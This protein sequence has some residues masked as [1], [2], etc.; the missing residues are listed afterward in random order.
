MKVI[1]VDD[2]II[3]RAGMRMIIPWE[4]LGFY[5]AGEAASAEEGMRLA[6]EVHPELMLVDITMPGMDGIEMIKILKNEL[7]LCRF[8]ILTCH[9]EIQYLTS[10]IRV[11]VADYIIK[12]ALNPEEITQTLRD[13]KEKFISEKNTDGADEQIKKVEALFMKA[14][15]T[16]QITCR[17]FIKQIGVHDEGESTFFVF[18]SEVKK[19][20]NISAAE[21]I[22][23]QVIKEYAKFSFHYC[24]ENKIVFLIVLK[25]G[26]SPMQ[27][28]SHRCMETLTSNFFMEVSAGTS[29]P[30]NEHSLLKQ[31]VKQAMA[32]ADMRWI[33]GWNCAHFYSL[34]REKDNMRFFSE[35][36]TM[37]VEGKSIYQIGTLIRYLTLINEYILKSPF[38]GKDVIL[39][40]FI[41]FAFS[42]N[43]KLEDAG[44]GKYSFT[45]EEIP[46]GLIGEESYSAIYQTYDKRM[47][48]ISDN[49]KTESS[50]Q[51]IV[52]IKEYIASHL[53]NKILLQ[54]IA[55]EVHL[56]RTY[57][58]SLFKK[59]TGININDYITKEK[60]RYAQNLM[61]SGETIS[62][63][64]EKVGIQSE[65]Y[66]CK[67]FRKECHMTPSQFVK[68][69]SETEGDRK[70]K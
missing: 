38:I 3:V 48:Y 62:N 4:D 45:Q 7:P 56:T 69:Y 37:Y 46:A 30:G 57:V 27:L 35:A 29:E 25:C 53:G 8:I 68:E 26:S 66:F 9:N 49:I 67:L 60:L 31:L 41:D 51:I 70:S 65:S 61:L 19:F 54:D 11:G 22:C 1:I 43:S 42:V 47:R 13:M 36:H 32:A 20:S 34:K 50:L 14:V 44:I 33:S 24:T 55:E 64:V 17:E 39:H 2:E 59:E 5:I 58:S 18:V 52:Q 15:Q 12:D 28:I 16:P 23:E 10:A 40:C 63:V 6:R 21:K